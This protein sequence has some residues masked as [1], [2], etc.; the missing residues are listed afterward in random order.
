MSH[1]NSDVSMNSETN[2]PLDSILTDSSPVQ[3]MA[4][5]MHDLNTSMY[6]RAAG[7]RSAKPS[8][9]KQSQLQIW[10]TDMEM[11]PFFKPSY[12][13]GHFEM[14][15]GKSLSVPGPDFRVNWTK[16]SFCGRCLV[17]SAASCDSSE[18][19]R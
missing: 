9:T 5:I 2:M 18:W 3:G 14:S 1:E 7:S 6:F 4:T 13:P 19:G 11:F 15:Y 8:S 17:K 12:A 10:P 16:T